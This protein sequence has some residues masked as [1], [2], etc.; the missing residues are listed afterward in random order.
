M[1]KGDVFESEFGH[2]VE[3]LDAVGKSV[4]V[5]LTRTV[6]TRSGELIVDNRE[7]VVPKALWRVFIQAYEQVKA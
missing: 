7:R 6:F 3:V 5:A 1:K 4:T 2:R